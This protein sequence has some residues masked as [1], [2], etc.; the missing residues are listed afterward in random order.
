MKTNTGTITATGSTNA[1]ALGGF[2]KPDA[3]ALI[4]YSGTTFT[5][6]TVYVEG[7]GL[8]GNWYPVLCKDVGSC[9]TNVGGTAFSLTDGTTKAVVADCTPFVDVRTYC[10]AI[11]GGSLAVEIVTDNYS[12]GQQVFTYVANS[13]A[14]GLSAPSSVSGTN[15]NAFDVGQNGSTY[16]ALEV[17]T[18]TASSATGFKIKSAAAASGVALSVISSGTNEGAS[19]DTKG[20]GILDLQATATGVVRIGSG[21]T[22][23]DSKP[24]NIGTGTDIVIQWDGTDLLVSQAAT[25]SNIKWGVSGAGINHIFYGDTATYDM[26]WDQ[27][28]NQLLFNDNAKVSI[29]TGNDIVLSW[30][31]TRLN[32]TQATTNS[33]IRWGV[34]GAGMDQRWYGDT[35]SADL[36]WDQSLDALVFEG[37]ASA[38][39]L[40]TSSTTAAAITGVTTLTLDDS[41]GVFSV[42]QAAAYDIAL[43]DPTTGPGCKYIFYLTGPAANNVTI[44]TTGASTFVGTIINDVTS[45]IVATGSTLTFASGTAAL[46]DTIEAISISTSLYLI[47]AV[48]SAAGGITVA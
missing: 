10:N 1:V 32:V 25:D 22:F 37:V 45:V 19:I 48:T 38:R 8:D 9:L 2:V 6:A 40:R 27:T 47:R 46:G 39:G 44:S 43:P 41:G 35:A 11:T 3:V 13:T 42:S 12:T 16:P 30:D 17:D 7:K 20:S 4:L 23:L 28:N 33:E 24:L 26:Q 36:L 18:S 21:M 29:G 15:A 5:G 31:A 14:T 34:D